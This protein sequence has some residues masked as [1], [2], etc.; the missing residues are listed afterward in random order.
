MALKWELYK[1]PDGNFALVTND[2]PEYAVTILLRDGMTVS[3]LVKSML[4]E[5]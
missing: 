1:E 3:E 2:K 4:E 5:E